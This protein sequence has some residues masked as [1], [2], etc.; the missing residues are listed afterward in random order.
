VDKVAKR[1]EKHEVKNGFLPNSAIAELLAVAAGP[2]KM[3]LQKALHRCR[4]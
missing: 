3:P 1:I 4:V 2:A